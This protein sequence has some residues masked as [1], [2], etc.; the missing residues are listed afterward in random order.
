MLINIKSLSTVLVMISNLCV[1]ICNCFHNRGANRV[2][3]TSFR[4]GTQ[5]PLFD[6]LVRGEPHIGSPW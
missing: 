1:S 4:R 6:A 2:K 5:V 3:I